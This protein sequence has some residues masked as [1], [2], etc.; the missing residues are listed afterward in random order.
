MY[1]ISARSATSAAQSRVGMA[2]TDR[3]VGGDYNRVADV[4][5]RMVF[6]KRVHGVVPVRAELRQDAQRA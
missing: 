5:G 3:V 1:N 2:Y 4:D 6:G